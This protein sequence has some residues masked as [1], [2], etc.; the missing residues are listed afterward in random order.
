MQIGIFETDHFEGAY[1]VIKLFDNGQNE[2]TIFTYENS[3]RQFEYLF[4]ENVNRY[5]WVIKRSSESK[6]QF[7]YRLYKDSKDKNF[8]ILYLN[9]IADN[10]IVYAIMIAGLRNM[11]IISTLHDI[12]S[13][14]RFI[15]ALRF[16]RFIRFIGKRCLIKS[17]TEFNVVSSTMVDYLKKKLPAHKKVH[18]VPGSVFEEFER[19]DISLKIQSP[20]K[21]V[22]PGSIDGRRR[23][24]EFVFKL[25]AKLNEKMKNEVLIVLLGGSG[26]VYGKQII[27]KCKSYVLQYQNLQFSENDIVDQP[28]FD[29]E[30]DDADFIFIP[31]VIDTVIL[32]GVPETYGE[33]ISSGNIFDVIKHAKPFIIPHQLNIPQNLESSCFKYSDPDEIANFLEAFLK[34][35][36][37]YF[38]WKE[39]ALENSRAYTIEK[40]RF[41]NPSLFS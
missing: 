28:T 6:Y 13:H 7:I 11:R 21:I 15:P 36:D 23:N 39:K 30:L 4:K 8:D 40:I 14:F 27:E 29:R 33:S 18:C 24:Y 41:K 3:F 26:S 20:I 25:L 37:E 12:N 38:K 31:S 22:I 10:H 34:K 17:V 9:T 5:H 16:R 19:P 35:P 2:I 1:P 32:D